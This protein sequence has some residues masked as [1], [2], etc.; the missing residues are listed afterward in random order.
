M[1]DPGASMMH[2]SETTPPPQTGLE[3]VLVLTFRKSFW[4]SQE[5]ERFPRRMYGAIVRGHST[6]LVN[7]ALLALRA[8]GAVVRRRPRLILFGSAHRLVP[9][10]LVLRRLGVL[11]AKLVVTN[12]VYFGPRW[13]RHADRVIVYSRRET[14]GRP[15]YRYLPIPADGNFAS[16]AP[17]RP[18]DPYVFAGGSTLRDFD[19]VVSALEG[20]GLRLLIV[21]DEPQA[22][23]KGGRLPD[24]CEVR[25]RMPLQQFLTLMAEATVV[26]VPLRA[27][28]APHGHTTVAQALRL[29]KAVVT[30]RGASVEDYVR[31]GVEGLLVEP[32]DAEGYRAAIVRLASD[33]TLRAACEARARARAHEFEYAAFA[34][35]L[36]T[37]CLEVLA[38]DSPPAG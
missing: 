38:E 21:T 4:A 5:A 23:A 31:D 16:I 29:G 34:D 25:G 12:Q 17:V 26:V 36:E 22:V 13:G 9:A 8:I 37:M 14:E 6:G 20:T 2:A 15:T 33:D 28:V 32:G 24:G 7:T 10:A 30:T 27:S 19:T 35:A 3:D 1:I 11:R 18:A